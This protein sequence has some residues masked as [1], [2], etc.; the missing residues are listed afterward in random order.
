MKIFQL[1]FLGLAAL[2]LTSCSSSAKPPDTPAQPN[3]IAQIQ[4]LPPA[5][6]KQI[7]RVGNM[8]NWKNPYL[9][10]R[11]DGIALLDPADNEQKILTPDQVIG[12][13]G[14]LPASAWPYGRVVAVAE[15]PV[16]TDADKASLRKNRAVL[17]GALEN[18]H[19]TINWVPSS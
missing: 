11:I 13:L 17:A 10:V 18:L 12:A 15:N 4:A 1:L 9:I 7:A 5:D 16:R 19:V 8:R 2:I 3:P 6:T 14:A